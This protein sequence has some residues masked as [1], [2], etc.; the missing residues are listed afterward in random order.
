MS[1]GDRLLHVISARREVSWL[2]FKKCVDTVVAG[3]A[4][5]D[6]QSTPARTML[7]RRL[8]S[9]GH[10]EVLRTPEAIRIVA[11]PSCLVRL[12]TDVPAA[13]FAGARPIE[14]QKIISNAVM[15]LGLD[16]TINGH[17]GEL[18]AC[19]PNRVAVYARSE[20]SLAQCAGLLGVGYQATPACWSC[21]QLS[22]EISDIF[23]ALRWSSTTELQWKR[24][25]F[26]VQRA[27]FRSRI[28]ARPDRGLTRYLDPI[29]GT[30]R[31][32]LWRGES[33]AE[34]D[35]DWGRYCA[36]RDAGVSVVH[37]DRNSQSLGVPKTAPLPRILARALALSSGYAPSS[38]R[39][40]RSRDQS[41]LDVFP[42]VPKALADLTAGK[43]G[44]DVAASRLDW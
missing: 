20:E 28:G 27:A 43:L 40:P 42:M 15:R 10:L 41:G 31:Y 22:V 1:A 39:R 12:P 3:E 38:P 30:F 17:R 16:V 6:V 44:Q 23:G 14:L 11:A 35:L 26:D 7:L 21:G 8:D 32:W 2:V 33:S 37:Y 29:K 4:L 24:S 5:V 36:F 34:V 25:D 18:G 13:V 19:I 9:L